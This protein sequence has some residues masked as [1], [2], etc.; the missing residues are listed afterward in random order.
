MVTEPEATAVGCALAG[1]AAIGGF[2]DLISA[3][4]PRREDRPGLIDRVQAETEEKAEYN[5]LF[6]EWLEGYWRMMGENGE[7]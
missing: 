1:F 4:R 6:E 5:D 3:A 2:P 7:S